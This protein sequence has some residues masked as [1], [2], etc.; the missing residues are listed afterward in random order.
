MSS[1]PLCGDGVSMTLSRNSC[2]S[3]SRKSYF[4]IVVRSLMTKSQRQY[5]RCGNHLCIRCSVKL[6]DVCLDSRATSLGQPVSLATR[7]ADS[8]FNDP[9]R[10]M[11]TFAALALATDP[12]TRSSLNRKPDRRGA[13]LIN[14][15]MIKMI[16]SQA[17]FQVIVCLVLHFAGL[18]ILGEE[19]NVGN[20]TELSTLVF[21]VFVFCQI[22]RY[23][24]L[25]LF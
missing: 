19:N 21:N 17:I 25:V 15:D 23:P 10:I 20:N 1:L 8:P 14:V 2:S 24:S 5:H 13:P 22:C 4:V 11:D 7:L 16:I 3:R 18:A 12:A 9:I 6:G